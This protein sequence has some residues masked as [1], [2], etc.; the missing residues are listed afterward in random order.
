M[1]TVAIVGGGPAGLMAAQAL[2]E[3]GVAVDLY[4]AMPTVGRKFLLAGKGGLNLTHSEAFDAFAARFGERREVLEP[5]LRDFDPGAV[6]EWAL[7]LGIDTFVGTSGRVFPRDMKAAPLLRAWLAHLRQAGVRFHM[8]HR[9]IGLAPQAEG[10]FELR[11]AAPQGERVVQR[12]VA[13]LALGGAS[14]PQLG[15]DGAW[16]APLRTLGVEVRPLAPSNCGF[17]V[18]RTDEAGTLLPGWS[19]FLRTRFAGQPV[20]NAAISFTGSDGVRFVQQG[21]FVITEGGVEGSL[22][23][24]ASALLRDA[25]AEHGRAVVEIDLLPARGAAFVLAELMRPRGSRSLSTHLKSRLGI[26]GVKAALL[27]ELLPRRRLRRSGRA[28]TRHQGVAADARGRPPGG[29]GDQQRRWRAFRVARCRADG[30]HLPGA[31]RRRRNARLGSA[32]RRLPVD[33]VPGHRACRGAGRILSSAR[34]SLTDRAAEDRRHRRAQARLTGY[35]FFVF[36]R[37]S[38]PASGTGTPVAACA[39]RLAACH[40]YV[41]AAISS[42]AQEYQR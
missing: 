23:Y 17:D 16:V 39:C 36:G 35:R 6:R 10:G 24:A 30:A 38:A 20:K 29:R 28:R 34:D 9:L 22:I 25:I 13:L 5:L 11:F 15:S 41:A 12:R 31:V 37:G 1:S 2:V 3:S 8:R 21:E 26:D 32:H 7:R 19:E 18:G 4:D 40:G 27:R 33:R 42:T 14:W